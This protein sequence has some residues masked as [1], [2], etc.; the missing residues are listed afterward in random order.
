MLRLPP[1]ESIDAVSA[2]TPSLPLGSRAAPML[3]RM[4]KLTKGD[5]FGKSSIAVFGEPF[6]ARASMRGGVSATPR[7]RTR[8][9]GQTRLLLTRIL[10]SLVCKDNRYAMFL[11]EVLTSHVLYILRINGGV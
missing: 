7:I 6:P 1:S 3:N 10:S 5:E 4:R 9:A 2:A 8:A 11:R